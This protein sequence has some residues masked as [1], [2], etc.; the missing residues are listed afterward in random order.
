MIKKISII[1]GILG[2]MAL[3]TVLGF[4][5]WRIMQ[6]QSTVTRPKATAGAGQCL[7][8]SQTHLECISSSC[9]RKIGAGSNQ[10]GCTTTGA[11][12][13]G[14]GCTSPNDC[15]TSLTC[16]NGVCV[17]PV[18]NPIPTNC[19]ISTYANH[20]CTITNK[21]DGTICGDVVDGAPIT[22]GVCQT[23][24]TNTSKCK[25]TTS[26]TCATGETC[27][28]YSGRNYGECATSS[29]QSNPPFGD[30]LVP[31]L[32]SPADGAV[33]VTIDSTTGF[34]WQF[35]TGI[36]GTG[37]SFTVSTGTTSATLS[38]I[39]SC[40][41]L[42]QGDPQWIVC[43]PPASTVVPGTKYYWKVT[44]IKGSES[45]DSEIRSFTTT[46]SNEANVCWGNGGAGTNAGRCY[47]CNGDG[48][49]NILD[50]SCFRLNWLK[51]VQ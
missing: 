12:C 32:I 24:G 18:C 50:F 20:V 46:G 41:N 38:P 40:T 19:Q 47:D 21:L 48:T 6:P 16:V 14:T 42:S 43:R 35:K 44:A 39:P 2:I 11:S 3:I 45:K 31:T 7:P 34:A 15:G 4:A 33:S 1:L 29:C 51:P 22:S 27:Q 28:L 25:C 37:I 9:I 17:P 23:N 13:G 8:P 49:V 5:V 26:S 36:C 30:L 10:G